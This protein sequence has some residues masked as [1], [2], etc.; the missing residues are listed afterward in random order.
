MISD[1]AHYHGSF[2][3]MLFEFFEEPI[4][5]ERM[6]E[7]GPGYYLLGGIVPVYLKLSTKRKGPWA[8]N[9]FR[10][11]QEAQDEIYAKYGECFTCLI[12]GKDG[13]AGLNME[14]LRCVLDDEFE[15][16][17]SIIVRRRLNTMYQIKGRNGKLE[18]RVSRRAI[19]EKIRAQLTKVTT[20]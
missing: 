20:E 1:T 12:C 8:F 10:G 4:T 17:E 19:Y 6:P 13:V 11:H 15:E 3:V 9:F 14:E 7:Y 18:N 5:V 16:Q 2:F